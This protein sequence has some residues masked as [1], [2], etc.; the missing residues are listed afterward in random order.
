MAEENGVYVFCCIQAESAKD[1][2]SVHFE[3]EDRPVFTVHYEDAAMVAVEAPIKIYHPK[4]ENLMTHQQ[5]ISKVMESESSVVPISFGNVFQTRMDTEVLLK[6]LYPQLVKLFPEVRNKIEIGLKVVGKKDW[7]E[8][9]VQQNEKV[10]K[11]KQTVA[12]KTEAAGYFDRIK[13]GEM[14]QDFFKMLKQDVEGDVHA[15]LAKLAESA[16]SNETLGEKMLLN[17]AYLIDRDKEEAF[18]KKVNE[19]HERWK[20]KVDFKYTGPWPA[21][22]FINIKLK[23]EE[24]T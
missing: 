14:A 3:G 20:D 15:S 16:K 13:L 22:N 21:Y 2:G 1:F 7:L 4:K 24:T 9:Q 17:G 19:L 18:D 10:M 5:V 11:Q 23:V 12:N 6:N 8:N